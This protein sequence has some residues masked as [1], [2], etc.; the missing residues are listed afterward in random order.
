MRFDA[1]QLK[2]MSNAV[3]AYALD[4]VRCAGSGHV[5]IVLG[6][7]DIITTVYANFLRRGQDKFILS[8]GHGSALLYSVLKLAGYDIGDLHSF[9]KLGGLPGHPEFGFDGV[10]ATTGPLGQGVGNAVGMALAAK[11]KKSDERVYC[12]CSDGDL[13]EGVASEAITFAG[14]YKLDN[15]ILLWD[16]NGIS[17]DG[18][19]LTD[20]D[21]AG[22]MSAAG[23]KV[24]RINGSDT[25]KI[26]KSLSDA[27]SFR[28]PVFIQCKTKIGQ[29]SSL[30]GTS[31]AH[32]LALSDSEMMRLTEKFISPIGEDLWGYVAKDAP[33][34]Y[35][36]N[37]LDVCPKNIKAP[38]VD[39]DIVN[40]IS[41]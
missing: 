6:A 7:A 28:S 13:M 30:A 16:D 32:G 26:D 8:A 41:S 25:G 2:E 19:A 21:V 10:F 22:R 31:A 27:V 3:K 14:R 9:R 35:V 24:L 18:Q 23:W 17:I 29:G 39:K 36:L 11:I 12:L 38:K 15:L 34:K 33:A 5:G 40:S 37:Q 20:I 1:K 4:A